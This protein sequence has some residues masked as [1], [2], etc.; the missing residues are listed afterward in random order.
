MFNLFC[1]VKSFIE[2]WVFVLNLLLETSEDSNF[3]SSC[4]FLNSCYNHFHFRLIAIATSR[5]VIAKPWAWGSVEV[6][7]TLSQ[8]ALPFL[9]FQ[10]YL[11]R[12]WDLCKSYLSESISLFSSNSNWHPIIFG[13]IISYRAWHRDAALSILIYLLH[14]LKLSFLYEE[15]VKALFKYILY[16]HAS[17]SSASL[18][19]LIYLFLGMGIVSLPH[20]EI[21]KCQ[22]TW[23]YF[24]TNLHLEHKLTSYFQRKFYTLMYS[25]FFKCLSSICGTRALK[26]IVGLENRC[27][28]VIICCL[29]YHEC[30]MCSNFIFLLQC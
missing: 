21:D 6:N 14:F 30:H 7:Q 20:W 2:I 19:T 22:I 8:S 12:W 26:L 27:Y 25:C 4:G 1:F 18:S 17:A 16:S 23:W 29:H 11:W 28:I 15:K 5:M 13:L 3:K 24:L 9:F 10:L